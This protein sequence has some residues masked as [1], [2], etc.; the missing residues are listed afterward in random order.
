MF[1]TYNVISLVVLLN[2]L[3]AMMNNSYQLIA[4]SH[5]ANL[6]NRR[7]PTNPSSATRP[8]TTGP[9]R[10]RVEVRSHQ[11]VDELL[12]RGWDAASPVQHRPQPQIHLVPADVAPQ[13]AV[14]EGPAAGGRRAQMRKPQRI[15]GELPNDLAF[16][17]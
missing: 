13:Q 14:Q 12:R 2:M 11:A 8:P 16:R 9:R 10:H 4:V 17:S 5:L 15:H 6:Q 7:N 1:G 3:I